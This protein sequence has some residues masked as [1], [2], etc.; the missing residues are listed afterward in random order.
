MKTDTSKY[1]GFTKREYKKIHGS[2]TPG[3]SK[4]ETCRATGLDKAL[5]KYPRSYKT[6]TDLYVSYNQKKDKAARRD[7][8]FFT[9]KTTQ[10]N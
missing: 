10:L 4:T 8:T 2:S 6:M 3:T 7:N 1:K 5:A 9:Q